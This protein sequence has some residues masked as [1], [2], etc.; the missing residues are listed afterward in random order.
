MQTNQ[1][2]FYDD[3]VNETGCCPRFDPLPWDDQDLHFASK[4]FTR[5]T[6]R[7][8]FHIPLNM[9]R[10]FS[11]VLDKVE[12]SGGYDNSDFVVLSR[13][14]S[15]WRAEHLFAT[16]KPLAGEEQVT[17]SGDFVTK[18]YEGPYSQMGQWFK[19]MQALAAMQGTKDAE[20]YFFYPTCPKCAKA[21]GANHV[22]GFAKLT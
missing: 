22:I 7:S 4:P 5:A 19:D 1:L 12:K 18:A 11:R 6:T 3:S 17:L 20:V 14:L 13:D 9:G 2:P 16:P 10:V 21:Y 8:F 15:P